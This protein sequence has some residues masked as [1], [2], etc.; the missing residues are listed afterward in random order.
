MQKWDHELFSNRGTL[1]V[2][3][4]EMTENEA[5]KQAASI[6]QQPITCPVY[7]PAYS[8]STVVVRAL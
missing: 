4:A 3:P 5:L 1:I 7:Y 8:I 2:Y 6:Y